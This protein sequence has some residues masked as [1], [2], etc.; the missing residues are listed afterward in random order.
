[1]EKIGLLIT[2][3]IIVAVLLIIADLLSALL[4]VVNAPFWLYA[5]V[6]SFLF[7]CLV[8]TIS[9]ILRKD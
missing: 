4:G 8:G 1:M 5:I 9:S 6:F 7:V 2:L 3:I